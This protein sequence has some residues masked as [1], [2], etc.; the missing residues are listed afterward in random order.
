MD[1]APSACKGMASKEG[2]E[3]KLAIAYSSKDEVE[4]TRQTLP[5]IL[6]ETFDGFLWCDGS[7]TEDG[8]E[9]PS[10]F[11]KISHRVLGGADAA[12]AW[13]LTALLKLDATHVGLIENDC[14]MDHA[15]LKP[16]MELFEKGKADGL[17][18]GAVSPRS[19]VDRVLVQ[20]DGFGVMHNLGAGCVI[21]TRRAAEIVLRSFRTYWWQD[22]VRLFAQISGIDLRTY[23]AFRG[24]EQWVT[25]DWGWDAQLAA[26]GLASLALTPAK[27]RM[28][29]QKIPLEKQGLELTTGASDW[30]VQDNYN[31]ERYRDNLAAI[32]AGRLQPAFPGAIMR[33]PEG[34]FFFPHQLGFIPET[35]WQGTTELVWTQGFGPFAYRAGPG[36][37][38]LSVRISGTSSFLV[39]GGPA[40]ATCRIEDTRSGFR[41][42]P[43]IPPGLD[44]PISIAVPGGP[45]PRAI[46]LSMDEGAIFHGIHTTDIQ[47]LDP[48]FRFDWQQLPSAT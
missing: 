16:T 32:R 37:A 7:V 41:A 6:E 27:C 44:Q 34:Q 48:T 45:V 21:F 5:N 26:Y 19:Y 1:S 18:V 28:I 10:E 20:R 2:R 40:G 35:T 14:L 39:S 30:T 25:T 42:Q 24:N 43:Q 8:K 29:G 33:N 17:D 23:A 13:K 9:L 38:S 46:T 36:G 15:W 47:M 31:F 12:I 4:N 22:N 11:G 3:V